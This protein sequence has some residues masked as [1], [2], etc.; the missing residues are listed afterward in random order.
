MC[1]TMAATGTATQSGS[2]LFAKNSDRE[3]D[4][5]Q[6]LEF[7]PAARHTRGD[8]VK[9]TH[10]EID[11]AAA[12]HAIV[13]SKPYWI[14]GAEI[15]ANEHGLVI[16]NEAIFSHVE[17][18]L[19]PGIIGMDFLRLAL[20]RA[21]D[22]EE[23][24]DLI[25][26]LLE[27]HGQSGNC[28]ANKPFS[29]HNSYILADPRGAHVLETV[30]RDW[31][32]RP[33]E[34][35]GAISNALTIEQ[36]SERSRVTQW[37]EN[38]EPSFKRAFEEAER[39]ISGNFRQERAMRLLEAKQPLDEHGLFDILRDHE[40][41][42]A[43]GDRPPCRICAH[44]DANPIGQT[45]ASWVSRLEP[46]RQIHWVTATAAPCT[47]IF[48][49][50]V[51]GVPIPAHGMVPGR[52]PDSRSLWWAHETLRADLDKRPITERDAFLAER[53]RLEAEFLETMARCPPVTDATSCE[54]AA[55]I[56]SACWRQALAF[57]SRWRI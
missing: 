56:V 28:M 30:G 32:V 39:S 50:V 36:P 5:A 38:A 6:H 24:I 42:P 2:V 26:T 34:G 18:P 57:E 14:W 17:A 33:I 7:L 40:E 4:E 29:Y 13:I 48:K 3:F 41:G 49:P 51:V 52:T 25:V 21:T 47:S 45:T 54:E 37:P 46:E 53:N 11:Q 12:T 23:A 44:N 31:A 43:V 15:G 16:G 55:R 35:F 20:E 8:R 9:L 10:I 27:G 22:A 1:D 19:E